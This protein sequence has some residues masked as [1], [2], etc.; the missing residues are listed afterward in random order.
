MTKSRQLGDLTSGGSTTVATLDDVGDV[1]L[2]GL[3]DGKV[4][5]RDGVNNLWKPSW[6]NP[7]DPV[8]DLRDFMD[9]RYGVGG[10]TGRTGIGTGTDCGPAIEDAGLALQARYGR[11]TIRIPPKLWLMNTPPSTA[12]LSG[13]IVEG[14]ASPL[15][16]QIVF[17]NANAFMFHFS[18]AGGLSGGG[19]KH[20]ALYIE[21]GLGDTVS[22]AVVLQGDASYQPD[23]F[24]IENIYCTT[25]QA[26]TYWYNGLLINGQAR[27]SPQ[28]V[29]VGTI[30]NYQQFNCRNLGVGLYSALQWSL[31]NVGVYT[32]K[33]G[34]ANFQVGGG[35]TPTTN[36]QQID[37]AGLVCTG[38][39]NLTNSSIVNISGLANT[40]AVSSTTFTNSWVDVETSGVSGSFGSS[41]YTRLT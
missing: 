27:V 29:R 14:A 40:I 36:S 15:S 16:C 35:G 12:S 30:K 3:E 39:L 1:N 38:E 33:G 31:E 19:L 41:V 2:T 10:W 23:Q 13:N 26:S 9:A 7:K 5:Y 24:E 4:L 22:S 6:A 21:S 25:L 11:G 32:G 8:A 34:G 20:L 28:G 17:N 18:G 37:I